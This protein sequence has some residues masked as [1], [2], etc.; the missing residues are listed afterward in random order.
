VGTTYNDTSYAQY[1][2]NNQWDRQKVAGL[3]RHHRW[4]I[5][6]REWKG[7]AGKTDKLI[8]LTIVDYAQY[9]GNPYVKL[10]ARDAAL[11]SGVSTPTA[12]K[13]LRRLVKNGEIDRPSMNRTWVDAMTYRLPSVVLLCKF[14]ASEGFDCGFDGEVPSTGLVTQEGSGVHLPPNPLFTGGRWEREPSYLMHETYT[15]GRQGEVLRLMRTEVGVLLGVGAVSVALV[16]QDYPL[17]KAEIGRRA[18]I[19]RGSVDGALRR[20][21]MHGLA[22]PAENGWIAGKPVEDYR[23]DPNPQLRAKRVARIERERK[24]HYARFLDSYDGEMVV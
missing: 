2:T 16:L 13:S 1:L 19:S 21:K 15:E 11:S 18:E 7:K 22:L 24:D 4:H 5:L 10:S 3:C 8:L 14:C 6:Q 17:S 9:L 12:C 20:L 23:L